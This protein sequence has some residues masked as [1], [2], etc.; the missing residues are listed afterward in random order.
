MRAGAPSVLLDKR[1]VLP[2]LL[3]VASIS[4]GIKLHGTLRLR[5]QASRH[6]ERNAKLGSLNLQLVAEKEGLQ[7]MLGRIYAR[8]SQAAVAGVGAAAEFTDAANAIY[9]Q[10]HDRGE[11]LAGKEALLWQKELELE[12]HKRL[13][14]ARAQVETELARFVN[15]LALQCVNLRLQ[16]PD[17]LAKRP[18]VTINVARRI[19]SQA[20]LRGNA[21]FTSPHGGSTFSFLLKKS[22]SAEPRTQGEEEQLAAEGAAMLQRDV[23]DGLALLSRR[24]PAT[25]E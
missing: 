15:L 10:L 12:E 6:A 22:P 11:L 9:H 17:G 14:S 20:G 13:V 2:L 5:H 18:Y 23:E 16:V 7:A 1:L 19:A 4:G 3:L 21:T 24:P 25:S 8:Q